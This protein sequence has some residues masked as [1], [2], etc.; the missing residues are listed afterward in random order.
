MVVMSAS[1]W[2]VLKH[3]NQLERMRA[4][5]VDTTSETAVANAVATAADCNWPGPQMMA[6]P[7]FSTDCAQLIEWHTTAAI[8]AEAWLR[9]DC[10]MVLVLIVGK[11]NPASTRCGRL[12]GLIERGK[13]H[14]PR[15]RRGHR[16]NHLPRNGVR[17]RRLSTVSLHFEWNAG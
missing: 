10:T 9:D 1:G 17:V 14:G 2:V 3:Q 7:C 16:R 4:T 15:S 6:S 13:A 12:S 5:R 11:R 8:R